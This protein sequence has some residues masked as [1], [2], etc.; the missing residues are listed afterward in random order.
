MRFNRLMYSISPELKGKQCLMARVF[1]RCLGAAWRRW[2]GGEHH[3]WLE[4]SR[5]FRR[6]LPLRTALDKNKTSAACISVHAW[7]FFFF[8]EGEVNKSILRL[9]LF[10]SFWKLRWRLWSTGVTAAVEIFLRVEVPDVERRLDTAK[11]CTAGSHGEKGRKTRGGE[12][13]SGEWE[14]E[15]ER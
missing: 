4:F 8:L 2:A 14:R 7:G 9:C 3:V 6:T 1:L 12:R 5:L 10:F 15:R 13:R 11:V